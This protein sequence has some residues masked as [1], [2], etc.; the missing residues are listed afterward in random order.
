MRDLL[1]VYF[2]A[3]PFWENSA[4]FARQKG[5]KRF[6]HMTVGVLLF[7]ARTLREHI[8]AVLLH[9][10][11]GTRSTCCL[12]CTARPRAFFERVEKTVER[13]MFVCN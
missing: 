3:M 7:L 9:C 11:F 10:F 2:Y 12:L 8:Q 5:R 6:G 13:C 4:L 1:R